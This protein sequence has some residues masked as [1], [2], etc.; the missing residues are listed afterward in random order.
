MIIFKNRGDT[1]EGVLQNQKH[2]T[3]NNLQFVPGE[4]ILIQQTFSTLAYPTQKS[5]RWIMNY[6]QTYPDVHNES[7]RIW[8]RHW[9]Y[10]IEGTNLRPVEGFDIAELQVTN[11]NYGQ[12]AITHAYIDPLDEAAVLK[13]IGNIEVI[14]NENY[15]LAH[16]FR[17]DL[18]GDIDLLIEFL[19]QQYAGQP[20]YRSLITRAITRPTALKNALTRRDGTTCRICGKEGFLKRTGDRY[21]ELHHMIELNNQAPNTLQSWN[22]LVLCPT[23]H[24][25]MHYGNVIS[26][27][28]NPGWRITI[29]RLVYVVA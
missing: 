14:P 26:E 29:D 23:C 12:G 18:N 6:V 21:C 17:Q 4:I 10:I 9:K 19:N 7:D 15:E 28:L 5:I 22:I 3:S 20:Q 1:M 8:G 27:F 24:K 2:A 13:W 16:E 11:L 25:Q